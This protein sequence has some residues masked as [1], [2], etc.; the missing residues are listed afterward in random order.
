VHA[1]RGIAAIL[2]T[3][4]CHCQVAR[5]GLELDIQRVQPS[6]SSHC[7]LEASQQPGENWARSGFFFRSHQH[8]T[9]ESNSNAIGVVHENSTFQGVPGHQGDA[10]L[11]FVQEFGYIHSSHLAK[12]C[13]S[14]KINRVHLHEYIYIYL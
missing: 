2:F 5:V 13:S 8:V 11:I 9:G 14:I 12:F 10:H 3:N 7:G 6:H 1:Q 4:R